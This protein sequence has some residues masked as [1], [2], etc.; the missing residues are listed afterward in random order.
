MVC[1]TCTQ[2]LWVHRDRGWF[3]GDPDILPGLCYFIQ[4]IS[5][6]SPWAPYICTDIEVNLV[7]TQTYCLLYSCLCIFVLILIN[8][9]LCRYLELWWNVP[10]HI[11]ED[12][13]VLIHPNLNSE[14][15]VLFPCVLNTKP[16]THDQELELFLEW[17]IFRHI[18]KASKREK[19]K[20]QNVGCDHL[21]GHLS[22]WT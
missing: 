4:H 19:P 7:E 5:C 10:T 2:T 13:L 16:G 15:W 20:R 18:K 6:V 17:V 12:S 21:N 22:I 1:L 9:D 11:L 14:K 3:G 8:T